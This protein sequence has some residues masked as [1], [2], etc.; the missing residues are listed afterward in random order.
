MLTVVGALVFARAVPSA[1]PSYGPSCSSRNIMC[2]TGRGPIFDSTLG[3]TEALWVGPEIRGIYVGSPAIVKT[4]DGPVVASHDFFGMSTLDTT[5]QVLIDRTGHGD[6]PLSQWEY[7]GNVSAM[8][9][10]TLFAHPDPAR[11]HELYLLGVSGADK[12]PSRDIVISKST[13]FGVNW[14]TPVS[15]FRASEKDGSYHCAPTPALFASDGRLYRAF[16]TTIKGGRGRQ[17][18]IISTAEPVTGRTDLL[19]PTTWIKSSSVD[20]GPNEDASLFA[21]GWNRTAK[22]SWEEGNAVESPNGEILNLIRI[23]GQ[24]NQNNTQNKAAVLRLSKDGRTLSFD[25]MINFPSCSSKFVIRRDPVTKLYLTLSNDATPSA[26]A[27][28]TV[29]ARNHLVL[30]AS[31]DLYHWDTCYVVLMDDTGTNEPHRMHAHHK[32]DRSDDIPL[33]TK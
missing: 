6:G 1:S 23:D 24:T 16:E 13:D 30:A 14:T 8:Y 27:Q 4:A 11:T 25:K 7:A 19:D 15:L 33:F 21:L 20:P 18:L 29:F 32:Y 12:S 22:W 9:W 31:A 2:R 28:D 5:T 10:G 26:I 3:L 17:A